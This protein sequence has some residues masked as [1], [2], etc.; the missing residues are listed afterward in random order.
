VLDLTGY[1]DRWSVPQGGRITFHVHS[2]AG[3][4]DARLV[5]LVHGDRSPK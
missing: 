4:Y 1:T 5:R 3:A 2:T